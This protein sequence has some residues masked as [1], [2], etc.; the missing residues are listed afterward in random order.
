M[1]FQV[2]WAYYGGTTNSDSNQVAEVT[3]TLQSF[4]DRNPKVS[5]NN[6][7]FGDPAPYASKAFMAKV[8]QNG[9]PRVFAAQENQ[10]INFAVTNETVQSK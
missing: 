10:E 6:N 4:L 5:I 3:S 7:T 8:S 2:E 1:A 9:I